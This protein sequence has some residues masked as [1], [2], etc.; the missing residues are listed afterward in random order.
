M[1]SSAILAAFLLTHCGE[2][3]KET[4]PEEEN[5]DAGPTPIEERTIPGRTNPPEDL[6]KLQSEAKAMP[7][8]PQRNRAIEAVA[9]DAVGV[10]QRMAAELLEELPAGYASRVR[11]VSRLALK[12]ADKSVDDAIAW[13]SSLNDPRERDEAFSRISV[14]MADDKPA[15]AIG[16]LT[17]E[18]EEQRLRDRGTVQIVERWAKS[19]PRA[20][21]EW[22]ATLPK[23]RVRSGGITRC[24]SQWIKDDPASAANWMQDVQD[25]QLSLDTVR[26]ARSIL[27]ASTPEA[28]EE[29]LEH[30]DDASLKEKLQ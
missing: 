29:F 18:V 17:T 14:V 25:A 26:A 3:D 11:I 9:W 22:V 13:A 27:T 1:I 20:A 30:V 21:L 2:S 24:L 15:D 16:L 23:N 12:I 5:T 8:G 4:S 7:P 6:M 19:D 10:D 28:R